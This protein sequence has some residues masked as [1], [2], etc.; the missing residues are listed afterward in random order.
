MRSPPTIS[1][2]R[3]LSARCEVDASLLDPET[4]RRKAIQMFQP[5][6]DTETS[7]VFPQTDTPWWACRV[8]SPRAVSGGLGIANRGMILAPRSAVHVPRGGRWREETLG[9]AAVAWV[10]EA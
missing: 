2:V 3:N 4:R 6:L 1:P 10:P 5:D 7:T 9:G 8:G